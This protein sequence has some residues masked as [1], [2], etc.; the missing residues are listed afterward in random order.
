MQ[1]HEAAV[2]GLLGVHLHQVD[3]VGERVLVAGEGVLGGQRRGASVRGHQRVGGAGVGRSGIEPALRFRGLGARAWG[4]RKEPEELVHAE[5]ALRGIDVAAHH[6]RTAQLLG[7]RRQRVRPVDVGGV[8]D[9]DDGLVE[10]PGLDGHLDLRGGVQRTHDD[11]VVEIGVLEAVHAEPHTSRIE[12]RLPH[13]LRPVDDLHVRLGAREA[14]ILQPE[15]AGVE[16]QLLGVP[17][18]GYDYRDLHGELDVPGAESLPLQPVQASLELGHR[19][20]AKLVVGRA[21][22]LTVDEAVERLAGRHSERVGTRCGWGGD[23]QQCQGEPARR[24]VGL[25]G[26]RGARESCDPV[27]RV[28]PP[29][30]SVTTGTRSRR[31]LARVNTSGQARAIRGN[32]PWPARTACSPS[33]VARVERPFRPGQRRARC[34]CVMGS[35]PICDVTVIAW[36]A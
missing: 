9:A 26:R 31:V 14:E 12:R 35:S 22:Q 28:R 10:P 33:G 17:H 24:M 19:E 18:H 7:H 25:L 36:S 4:G 8:A 13:L 23:G 15:P 16:Q 21:G 30:H 2:G 6:R 3:P 34:P 32:S 29:G 20:L 11:E 27:A 1:R 5:R